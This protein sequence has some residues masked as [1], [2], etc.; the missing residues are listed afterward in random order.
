MEMTSCFLCNKKHSVSRRCI[1]FHLGI[2]LLAG[3][4]GCLLYIVNWIGCMVIIC[5]I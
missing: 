3:K 5:K 1:K 4:N 2:Y